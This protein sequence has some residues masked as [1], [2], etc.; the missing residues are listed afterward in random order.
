MIS[1]SDEGWECNILLR[2]IFAMKV[3]QVPC[4]KEL[5][6]KIYELHIQVYEYMP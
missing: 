3:H 6:E 2:T 5:M 4:R 1:M